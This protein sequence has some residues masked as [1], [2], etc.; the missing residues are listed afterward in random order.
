[1]RTP[2]EPPERGLVIPPKQPAAKPNP[3]EQWRP[4]ETPGIERNGNGQ[5][6]TNIPEKS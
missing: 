3:A 5:L 1:M 4:T 6:K 2:N